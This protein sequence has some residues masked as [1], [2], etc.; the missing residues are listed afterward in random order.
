MA[1]SAVRA[2]AHTIHRLF[3]LS[4][5][6]VALAMAHAPFSSALLLLLVAP[7]PVERDAPERPLVQSERFSFH[8]RII[9]RVPRM[10]IAATPDAAALRTPLRWEE[11][12]ARKCVALDSLVGASVPT[13][14]SVDLVARDGTRLRARF[15]DGCKALDFY[16]GFYMRPTGDGQVCAKRDAIRARSGGTCQIKEFRELVPHR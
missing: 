16:S 10:P 6:D 14:Q 11:K 13:S 15:A 12:T 7:E 9:I 5:Y 4:V 3:K 1:L 8:Q 2:C